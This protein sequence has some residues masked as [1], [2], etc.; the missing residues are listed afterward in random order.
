MRRFKTPLEAL[1]YIIEQCV[2]AENWSAAIAAAR[3]A[4][5]FV[6]PRPQ[7]VA[8]SATNVASLRDEDLERLCEGSGAGTG[9]ASEDPE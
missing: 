4:A 9:A 5:P 1:H 7:P 2:A 8:A 3:A 6:H